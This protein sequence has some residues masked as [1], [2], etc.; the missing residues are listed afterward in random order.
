VIRPFS[1]ARPHLPLGSGREFDRIRSIIQ[2]LGERGGGLGDDCALIAERDSFLAISTDVSVERVHF[3]LDWIDLQEAG[4]RAA[5]AALSDLAAEGAQAI[6]LLSA[7]TVPAGAA[8]AEL[9]E[10]M[11]GIAAAAEFAEAQV[12]GGDLS[13]GPIWSMAV[14]VVGR[15]GVPITRAGAKPGDELWV[16]GELGAARVALDA[17]RRGEEPSPEA[18]A[19]FAH[20]EP[21]IEAGRWLAANSV[22]AMIDVSDGI[23]G[24][25]RHLSAASDVEIAIDLESLPL[26]PGV[27]EAAKRQKISAG[28]FAA[29]AGEDYELLAALPA[30]FNAELEFS[31]DCGL[32]LTRIGRVAEGSGVRFLS[33]GR[34]IELGG[35]DHFG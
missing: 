29:E 32:A 7:V 24:D 1:A 22:R 35:F 26:G 16:T 18:R 17:W 4:W 31:R 3:H 28:Q 27:M 5:A 34:P 8:E 14:T 9:L 6:G 15:V 21:R 33:M 25:A 20:P 2:M 19:R 10:V 23:A 13:A 11:A 30:D 12:I